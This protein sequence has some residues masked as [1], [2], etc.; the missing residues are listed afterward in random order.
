MENEKLT[1]KSSS[2]DCPTRVEGPTCIHF[3]IL[4]CLIPRAIQTDARKEQIL[5]SFFLGGGGYTHTIMLTINSETKTG[6]LPKELK[7]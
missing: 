7:F 6:S 2:Q 5:T 4:P 1:N 3:P